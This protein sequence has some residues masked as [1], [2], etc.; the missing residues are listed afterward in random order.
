VQ[1]PSAIEARREAA[2][3]AEQI[4]AMAVAIEAR[5]RLWNLDSL[6]SSSEMIFTATRSWFFSWIAS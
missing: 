2:F 5:K 6:D 4:D 3:S 1:T